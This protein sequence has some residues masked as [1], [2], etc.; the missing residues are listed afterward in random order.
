MI[1]AGPLSE[2]PDGEG[3]RL[4]AEVPIAV[5]NMAG[6]VYAIDDT[7]T[8]QRASLT[9]GWVEDCRV[10]CPLHAVRFDLRTGEPDGLLTKVP[11]RTHQVVVVDGTVYVQPSGERSGG[12]NPETEDLLAGS[13]IN[14]EDLLA[15]SSINTEDLLAGSSINTEDLLAGSSIGT[16]VA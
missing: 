10:E 11:V 15:G 6:S 4:V 2:I 12:S 16:E 3:I 1:S 8:H 7:C 13:S 9:D 5:F 14:T